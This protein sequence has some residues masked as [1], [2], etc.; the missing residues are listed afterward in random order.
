[1]FILQLAPSDPH[2]L[3][4]HIA[5]NYIIQKCSS[6]TLVELDLDTSNCYSYIWLQKNTTISPYFNDVL[7]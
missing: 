3:P 5:Y 7:N 6:L 1:M 2:W 4:P